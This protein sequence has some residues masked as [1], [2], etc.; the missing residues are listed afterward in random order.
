MRFTSW[1]RPSQF[2]NADEE[3]DPQ[4]AALARV[5]LRLP[6]QQVI[7]ETSV[8]CS[9]LGASTALYDGILLAQSELNW[10]RENRI[11]A[12]TVEI[13]FE[14][15]FNHILPYALDQLDQACAILSDDGKHNIDGYDNTAITQTREASIALH[16][17]LPALRAE[18]SRIVGSQMDAFYE[19]MEKFMI[20]QQDWEDTGEW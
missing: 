8:A 11:E 4:R 2:V 9:Y 13:P 5:F 10:L 16:E 18:H 19:D 3:P 1:S 14:V 6:S 20:E 12:H 7:H 15:L 17:T